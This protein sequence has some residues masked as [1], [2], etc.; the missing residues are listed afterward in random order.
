MSHLRRWLTLG[1]LQICVAGSEQI[2]NEA[3]KLQAQAT[4]RV[5]NEK[6]T[7][8]MHSVYASVLC[9]CVCLWQAC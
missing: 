6:I 7:T 1:R 5:G 4:P 9:V 2:V 8:T 3:T